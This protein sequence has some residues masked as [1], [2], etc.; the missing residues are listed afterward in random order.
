MNLQENLHGIIVED[1][2]LEDTSKFLFW[3][4]CEIR[5]FNTYFRIGRCRSMVCSSSMHWKDKMEVVL[6]DN[7]LK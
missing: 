6:E 5:I 7:G 4:T 2:I 1:S 3:V